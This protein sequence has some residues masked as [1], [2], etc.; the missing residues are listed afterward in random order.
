M[1]ELPP[2]PESLWTATAPA[3]RREALRGRHAAEVAIVGAGITGL[4]AASELREAG[5]EVAIVEAGRV[6]GGVTGHTTAKITSLHAVQYADLAS[7]HGDDVARVHGEANQAGIAAYFALAERHGIE[8]DL[9]RRDHYAYA[10]D[11]GDVARVREEAQVAARLGLPAE[12]TAAV[13]LPFEVAGAVRFRDQAEFHPRRFALGL[14]AALEAAGVRIWEGSPVQSVDD[15]S[16]CRLRTHGGELEAGRVIVATGMPFLDRGL[17]WARMHPERSYVVAMEPGSDVP[18]DM[19][20]STES[21]THSIRSHPV[22]DG[23]LVLVGGQGHKVGQGGDTLARYR[24]LAQFG[25]ARLGAGEVRYRWSSQDNMPSDGLPSVG[26][27]WPFSER[28][29]TAT[30]YRKWGFAQAAA[31]AEILREAVAGREHR[32]ASAYDPQRI[33]QLTTGL[34]DL[35][36]ENAD[37]GLHFFADR[38]RRRAPASAPVAPGEGRVVSEHGRQVAVSRA[39][40]GTLHAVSARCTHVGCIVDWN[41]AEGSWDCPCHG[42]RF[43]PDGTVLQG[44]AVRALERRRAPGAG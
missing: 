28:L 20:I 44:P 23:E 12:F 33:S 17:W 6:G 8:C 24:E 1:T 30:G 18:R 38:V 36:K 22:G 31:A 37:A 40:D 43:A 2:R 4:L 25:R 11:A 13:P 29:L 26:R 14:A 15:G 3:T 19:F 7:R 21:P 5:A 41:P 10:P 35:V 39:Q 9:R 42:S 32:W 34:A 27:L 16:P